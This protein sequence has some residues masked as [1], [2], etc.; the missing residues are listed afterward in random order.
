M[1]FHKLAQMYRDIRELESEEATKLI[2]NL[3]TNLNSNNISSASPITLNI[4]IQQ[5]TM[6]LEPKTVAKD[7]KEIQPCP[8]QVWN[9]DEIVFDP[10]GSWLKV[11]CTYKFFTGQRIWKSQTEQYTRR[12]LS[13]L[14][15][16]SKCVGP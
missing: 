2:L 14:F 11:I 13:L 8:S 3:R 9:C 16:I 10:N 5:P 7:L 15:G 6:P 1:I 12:G 4:S